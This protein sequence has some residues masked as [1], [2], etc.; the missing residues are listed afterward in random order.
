MALFTNVCPRPPLYL[1]LNGVSGDV[2]FS[3]PVL[4]NGQIAASSFCYIL[5]L[6]QSFIKPRL[7]EVQNM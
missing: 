2:G 6:N 5:V 3:T 4:D 7:G 1:A